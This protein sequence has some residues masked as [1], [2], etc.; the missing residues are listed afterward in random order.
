[1][2]SLVDDETPSSVCTFLRLSSVARVIKTEKT[3]RC[4]PPRG[5]REHITAALFF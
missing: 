4:R 1:M 2:K 5:R 3:R